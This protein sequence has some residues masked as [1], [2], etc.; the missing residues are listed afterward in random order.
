MAAPASLLA[1]IAICIASSFSSGKRNFDLGSS[2]TMVFLPEREA[3]SVGLISTH[4][5]QEDVALRAMCRAEL[6]DPAA[7]EILGL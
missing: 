7:Q 5:D 6:S 2:I 1:W 3:R 4:Q